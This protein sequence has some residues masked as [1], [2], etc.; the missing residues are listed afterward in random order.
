MDE[1]TLID[2]RFTRVKSF[3]TRAPRANDEPGQY[4]YLK[5]DTLAIKRA[6]GSIVTEVTS[7]STEFTYGTIYDSYKGEYCMLDTLANSVAVY[8]S[9]PFRKTIA[10]SL[11][12]SPEQWR[13]RLLHRYP[14]PSTDAIRRIDE[15]KLSIN[16]SLDDPD[17]LW[18]LN[19][20][21]PQVVAKRLIELTLDPSLT[22]PKGPEYARAILKHIQE[23]DLWA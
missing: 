14:E 20:D 10:I 22:D 2:E 16:W 5:D 17:T 19:D 13:A 15:A 8:R 4:I 12:A 21:D 7:P 23:R 11:T 6:G 9:R 3:T 1:A 18:L